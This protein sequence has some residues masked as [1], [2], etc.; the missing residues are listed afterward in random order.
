MLIGIIGCYVALVRILGQLENI[1]S[2]AELMRS[3][4]GSMRSQLATIASPFH[5]AANEEFDAWAKDKGMELRSGNMTSPTA[6][7][8]LI[9][10]LATLM[11]P[12]YK[13]PE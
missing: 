10:A 5:R 8:V 2:D 11:R 13:R 3:D 9:N 7:R 12:K 4:T 6:M 1:A